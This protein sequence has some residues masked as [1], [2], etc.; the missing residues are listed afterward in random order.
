LPIIALTAHAMQGGKERFLACGMD[1][2]VSKPIKLEELFAVIANV[3][4]NV[5]LGADAKDLVLH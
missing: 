4:P 3:V 1:G 2:Y 5:H